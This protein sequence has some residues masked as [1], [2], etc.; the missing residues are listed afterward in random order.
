MNFMNYCAQLNM[1]MISCALQLH[2]FTR[3]KQKI[4]HLKIKRYIYICMQVR[5]E[6]KKL[7][8]NKQ[9]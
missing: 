4:M 9:F 3:N 1:R 2:Y 8:T 6:Y 5:T 7:I